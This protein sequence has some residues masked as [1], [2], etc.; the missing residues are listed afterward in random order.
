MAKKP[1]STSLAEGRQLVVADD[2]DDVVCKVICRQVR[3]TGARMSL[4]ESIYLGASQPR[5]C[6]QIVL[7]GYPDGPQQ[8]KWMISKV[9]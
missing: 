2:T 5:R 3:A 9:G 1:K 7:T 4:E 6:E 8:V